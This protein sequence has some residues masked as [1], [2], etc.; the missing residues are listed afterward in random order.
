MKVTDILITIHYF[1]HYQL[2]LFLANNK[3]FCLFF[4][5]KC[6]LIY[7]CAIF[8]QEKV[9]NIYIDKNIISPVSAAL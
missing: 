9:F 1:F 3:L 4:V 2:F 6:P 7:K 5:R 8:I